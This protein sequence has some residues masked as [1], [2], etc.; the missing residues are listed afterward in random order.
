M[1]QY[2][3]G[4]SLSPVRNGRQEARQ[5]RGHYGMS[6]DNGDDGCSEGGYFLFPHFLITFFI[7]PF[8]TLSH[9]IHEE[10]LHVVVSLIFFFSSV[11]DGH[12]ARRH[13]VC[14][15]QIYEK[16]ENYRERQDTAHKT[17]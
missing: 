6:D 14:P 5:G 4:A 12:I 15:P 2:S 3:P 10:M 1:R 9:N 16:S 7:S 13:Y 11:S 8:Y 17:M